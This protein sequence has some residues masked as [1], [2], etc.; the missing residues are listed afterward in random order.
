MSWDLPIIYIIAT[1]QIGI[2][3]DYFCPYQNTSMLLSSVTPKLCQY[4]C[5]GLN[6]VLANF[7]FFFPNTASSYQIQQSG[8]L[9]GANESAGGGR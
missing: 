9:Y 6:P 8:L 4:A 3:Y 2:G 7:S 1:F 5:T